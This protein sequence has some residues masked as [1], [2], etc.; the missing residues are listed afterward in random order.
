MSRAA[1]TKMPLVLVA[2]DYDD[3][4]RIYTEYLRFAGFRV[5]SATDGAEAVR[6]AKELIPDVVVM[7]L[8]MP[9]VDGWTA[10]RML[11][12]DPRTKDIYVMADTSYS[13]DGPRLAAWRSGCDAFVVKPVLPAEL[14]RR[15]VRRLVSKKLD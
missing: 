2:D 7:D 13:S 12:E 15:I 10:T 4:R 14:V 9:G 1:Q 3:T 6:K 5:A 8:S 11:K